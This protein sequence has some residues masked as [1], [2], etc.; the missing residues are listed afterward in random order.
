MAPGTLRFPSQGSITLRDVVVDFTQEEWRLLDHS[1][2]ELYKEVMLENVQ[3]L[4]SVGVRVPREKF[5]TCFQQGQSPSLLEQKDQWGCCPEAETNFDVK[6]RCINVSF[7]VEASG[8]QKCINDVP[9]D[10]IVSEIRDSDNKVNKI[11]MSDYEFDETAEKFSQYSVLNQHTKLNLGNDSSQDNE[12]STCFPEEVGF[13]QLPEKPPEMLMYQ[14]NLGEMAFD[15]SLDLISHPKSKCIEMFTVNNKVGRPFSQISELGSHQ[16]CHSGEKK[17]YECNQCGKA[18]TVSANLSRHQRIHTGEKPYECKQCGKTFTRKCHLARHFRIHT[19]EKPYECNQCGKAFPRRSRLAAH[20]RIHT[21]EKPY[22]CTQ[23]GKTFTQ[24]NYLASHQTIHTGEKPYGCTQC[25]KT[26][27][28]RASLRLHLRIHTG[29]KPYECTQCGKAFT[30][31]HQLLSHQTIHTG[32]KPYECKQ[33]GKAFTQ[34]GSLIVHLRTHTG[35]KPFECKQ[36]GKAF[37]E[38]GSL[39]AHHR[40]HTGEKPFECTQC[41]KTFR[42]RSDLRKHQRVHTSKKPYECI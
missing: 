40:I 19:G 22:E 21:G 34:K 30:R 5:G 3:N 7:F 27:T 38:K 37:T 20:Q 16:I 13:I 35:E 31:R 32:K 23:C 18:F 11:P 2:K 17:P 15:W 10:F 42:N 12:Y 33:C 14:G 28:E 6:E 1:Q 25:G 4:Q 41:G 36:C 26:F 24:R 8:P 39:G 29:E 9:C